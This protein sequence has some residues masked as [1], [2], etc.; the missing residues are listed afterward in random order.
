MDSTRSTPKASARPA[1]SPQGEPEVKFSLLDAQRKGF[2]SSLGGSL[3]VHG[4]LIGA[5]LLLAKNTHVQQVVKSHISL[6]LPVDIANYIVPQPMKKPGGGGGGGGDRSP[7]PASKGKLPKFRLE[8]FTPPTAKILNEQPKLVMD[9]SVVIPPELQP[10]L[11]N[12]TQFGD[13]LN[14][15]SL[16]SSGPG[17]GSGIGSGSNGGVGSGSGRGAGPGLG[18]GTGGGDFRYGSGVT[19]PQLLHRINPEYSEEARKA[20]HQGTVELY[21][22][23]GLDGKAHNIK[24]RRSLGLGLDEKA[25]EA[26]RQ[27]TFKPAINK[28]GQAIEVGALVTVHFRLL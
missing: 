24:V 28:D 7:L 4:M 15:I 2:F 8:Q 9:P 3:F 20:K 10:P 5:L 6:I 16:P 22:E 21:I 11:V 26:V 23:V 27:W 14:K 19:P 18:A 17:S 12:L 1:G 13:P 25:I